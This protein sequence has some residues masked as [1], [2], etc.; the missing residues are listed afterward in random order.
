M[1][2]RWTLVLG[3]L[4]CVAA[5]CGSGTEGASPAS[6]SGG[7]TQLLAAGRLDSGGHPLVSPSA[8]LHVQA[9]ETELIRLVN[10][11]RVS[12]GLSALQDQGEIRDVARA[13]SE[14][15]IAHRF[16]GHSSPE[17]LSPADRLDEAGVSWSGVG[18]NLAAGYGSPQAVFDAWM[19][20]PE[21][22][23]N[24]ESETWTHTGVGYAL[25]SGS[26]DSSSP[27]HYWTQTFLRP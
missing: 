10:G 8:D 13:H 14:H 3:L 1:N 4:V 6:A 11:Y 17:G 27:L 7:S 16:F 12:K 9:F 21:H 22:R 23:Q 25:D 15:M 26:S 2:R 24:I 5:G 18:E 20:S 19:L